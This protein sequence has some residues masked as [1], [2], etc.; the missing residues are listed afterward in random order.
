MGVRPGQDRFSDARTVR[1]EMLSNTPK[2]SNFPDSTYLGTSK[3]TGQRP[4]AVSRPQ[5]KESIVPT[6][7]HNIRTMMANENRP[8]AVN[9]ADSC[10][11]EPA[12]NV[13][14][15]TNL[16]PRLR[17]SDSDLSRFSGHDENMQRNNSSSLSPPG[18]LTRQQDQH[19]YVD[20]GA[21]LKNSDTLGLPTRM[22]QSEVIYG[23]FSPKRDDTSGHGRMTRSA[24]YPAPAHSQKLENRPVGIPEENSAIAT[25]RLY[26]R[27]PDYENVFQNHETAEKSTSDQRKDSRAIYENFSDTR[28]ADRANIADMAYQYTSP[29]IDSHGNFGLNRTANENIEGGSE[30]VNS[31]KICPSCNREFSRLTLDEFQLHVYECFDSNDEPSTLQAPGNVSQEDDRTCPMCGNTFP[32]T[33]PQETYEA[34][35]LAHFGEEHFVVVNS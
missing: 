35:V 34:H 10:N 11:L 31:L 29:N 33:V 28:V 17:A 14:V 15:E 4:V 27:E 22:T 5:I 1:P 19:A 8:Q 32:M 20:H 21:K 13:Y 7:N 18:I 9:V 2:Y 25:I 30:R 12:R 3:L 26:D 24:F 6:G 23:N 16:E